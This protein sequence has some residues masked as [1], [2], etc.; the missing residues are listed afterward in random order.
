MPPRQ[1]L[2]LAITPLLSHSLLFVPH[3]V[4]LMDL[5]SIESL[6]SV[7]S[8]RVGVIA[9][10]SEQR[11]LSQFLQPLPTTS[12]QKL[13]PEIYFCASRLSHFAIENSKFEIPLN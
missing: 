3:S 13:P 4:I 1:K 12:P 6:R 10:R 2:P 5:V 8:F 9:T 7:R 11:R